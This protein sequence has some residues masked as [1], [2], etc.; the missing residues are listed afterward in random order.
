VKSGSSRRAEAGRITMYVCGPHRVQP[1]AYR[2]CQACSGVSTCS[3]GSSVTL[4]PAASSFTARNVTDVDDK[5]IAA[6]RQ[7]EVD[8]SVI[9]ER[10]ERFYDEDMGALGV[11]KPPITPHATPISTT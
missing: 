6:A 2:Q 7:E 1:S 9:T 10:F 3:R 8:P 11:E 4:S 5:I